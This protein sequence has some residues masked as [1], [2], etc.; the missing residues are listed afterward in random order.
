MTPPRPAHEAPPRS[1]ALL[2]NNPFLTDA[3]SWKMASTLAAAGYRVTVVARAE[4][5]LPARVRQDGFDV[6]RLA[7]PDPLARLPRVRLPAGEDAPQ[8]STGLSG[9]LGS[10]LVARAAGLLRGTVGRGIQAA[11]YTLLTRQW[12]RAIAREM[13]QADVWQGE[14]LIMLPV[15]LELR[16]RR[17]GLVVYDAHDLDTQAGRFA[18][19]PAAWRRLLAR[20]ERRWARAADSVISANGGYAQEQARAWGRVPAVIWNGAPDFEP[21]DPPERRW[22]QRLGL[23][24]GVRVVLYLGLVMPGR[25]IMEL[26]RAMAYVP[27]A[28]LIVAGFGSDYERY[29]DDAASLPHAE[30][31]MFPGSV[32]H[33]EILP[34]VAAADVAAMPV[35]GDT[36]NHRL[37]V[38]TKLFDAMAAGVPVVA[39]DLPGMGPIVRATGCGTLCDPD[40]PLDIARAIRW[41]L[42]A[43]P[44]QRAAYRAACLE[45]SQ[46]TYGWARQAVTL[47][48]LYADL[49]SER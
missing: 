14:Q 4:A 40:D 21:L 9:R 44:E 13:P 20:S 19:L 2:V 6:L 1:V 7:Q 29:R 26:A 8:A 31:V 41:I 37:N 33:D 48:E 42:D 32:P 46:G 35:Q 43:S 38:P 24:R 27:D 47:R 45:A 10:G 49:L 23:P 5:G 11:R 15:A 22:H 36:L 17:G 3:R 25:G 16:R 28:V 30:R 12:A 18:R 39:S 34:F